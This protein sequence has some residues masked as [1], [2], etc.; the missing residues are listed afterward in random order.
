VSR[1][2][3]ERRSSSLSCLTELRH[4]RQSSTAIVDHFRVKPDVG[5]AHRRGASVIVGY[6]CG[7]SGLVYCVVGSRLLSRRP[8]PRQTGSRCQYR[9]RASAIVA[10][11]PDR[12]TASSAVVP[13]RRLP[14]PCQTGSRYRVSSLTCR[15]GVLHRRHLGSR[16]GP[17]RRR[18]SSRNIANHFRPGRANRVPFRDVDYRRTLSLTH[19]P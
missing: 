18:Q 11:Q 9:L 13:C 15:T 7:V 2:V 17:L 6:R 5:V 16:T 1:I 10:D 4:R 3:A 14:L 12:D 8:L 19:Q